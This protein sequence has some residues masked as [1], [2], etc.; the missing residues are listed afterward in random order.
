MRFADTYGWNDVQF[1]VRLRVMRIRCNLTQDEVAYRAGLSRNTIVK[2][3]SCGDAKLSTI[4]AI[5]N[6]LRM[7]MHAW[8]L[9]DDE[10][11]KWYDLN[12]PQEDA[13][14]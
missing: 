6:V 3:E 2:L 8:F 12:I 1:A 4:V 7:P 11:R 14:E 5:S 9:P 13:N 10:W